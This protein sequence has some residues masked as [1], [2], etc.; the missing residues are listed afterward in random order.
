PVLVTMAQRALPG[1]AGFAA[2]LT[3]GVMFA[4]GSLG[5]YL[6][7]LGADRLGLAQVLQANAL[8]SVAAAAVVLALRR[9]SKN[10]PTPL[11]S[12]EG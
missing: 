11:L 2:G 1:R 3:L 10:G 4:A 6:S 9:E 7:G 5:A 12:A 8:I